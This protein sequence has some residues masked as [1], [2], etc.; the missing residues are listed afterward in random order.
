MINEHIASP[1]VVFPSPL[2]LGGEGVGV[3]TSGWFGVWYWDYSVDGFILS[4]IFGRTTR[5]RNWGSMSTPLCCA[6]CDQRRPGLYPVLYTYRCEALR[7]TTCSKPYLGG[8]YRLCIRPVCGNLSYTSHAPRLRGFVAVWGTCVP[9]WR[10][11]CYTV[12]HEMT[13][14]GAGGVRW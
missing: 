14:K 2:P 5:V 12:D 1:A 6:R 3:L 4:N 8:G 9:V 13:R 7:K 11:T 10:K